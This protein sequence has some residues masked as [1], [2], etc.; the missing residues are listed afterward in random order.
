[1]GGMA[2]TSASWGCACS[3]WTGRASP[4]FLGDKVTSG[5]SPIRLQGCGMT[6]SKEGGDSWCID[7]RYTAMFIE[8]AGCENLRINCQATDFKYVLQ[9]S[10][11][12]LVDVQGAKKCML[13]TCFPKEPFKKEDPNSDLWTSNDLA[14]ASGGRQTITRDDIKMRQSWRSNLNDEADDFD[15][16]MPPDAYDPYASERMML[17]IKE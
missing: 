3:S 1:M 11:Y 5:T 7:M 8:R 6:R 15:F 9:V 17:H 10:F 2:T 12:K 13:E 4:W 14:R 16:E